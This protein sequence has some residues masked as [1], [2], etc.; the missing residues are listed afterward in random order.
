MRS[1]D[2]QER[3]R[4]ALDLHHGG[5]LSHDAW[6]ELGEFQVDHTGLIDPLAETQNS[7]K[8]IRGIDDVK[9]AMAIRMHETT[10]D[11]ILGIEELVSYLNGHIVDVYA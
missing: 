1:I 9:Y 11:A 10:I 3:S 7:L 2:P 6:E 8:S 4:L 5:Y